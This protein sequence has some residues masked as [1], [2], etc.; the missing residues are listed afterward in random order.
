MR[1]RSLIGIAFV[2]LVATGCGGLDAR[3]QPF[4]RSGSFGA[5]GTSMVKVSYEPTA[6]GAAHFGIHPALDAKNV[7][8]MLV[9]HSNEW[10]TPP[11]LELDIDG[12]SVKYVGQ[13]A[14]FPIKIAVLISFFPLD[15]PNYFISSD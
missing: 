13:T 8:T 11:Q 3:P 1:S 6:K 12:A 9:W 2:A 4:P 14:I 10:K 7:E 5:F 15:V